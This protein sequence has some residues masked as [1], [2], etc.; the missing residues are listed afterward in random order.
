MDASV[1]SVKLYSFTF[2]QART[3]IFATIFVA[4]N[5]IL[6]QLC[7][8]IPGGGLMF[9]PIYF[10][11][12]IAAYKY[13]IKAGLLIALLSPLV[14]SLLF[15][16]PSMAYIAPIMIKSVLLASACAYTAQRSG[17]ISFLA[18]LGAIVFYQIIGSGIEWAIVG[19]FS[20]AMGDLRLGIPGILLQLFGGYTLLKI[21]AKI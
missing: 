21:I 5:V 15:D 2:V 7:H 3:Y 18:L 6:P 10:F 16:M 13:G 19:D 12:L 20:E 17:K 11:T 9:L 14:N 1:S 4:G 8:L